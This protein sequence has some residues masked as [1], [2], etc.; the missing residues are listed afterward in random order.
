[1]KIVELE[2]HRL[3]DGGLA[4]VSKLGRSYTF[5]RTYPSFEQPPDVNMGLNKSLAYKMLEEALKNDV[6][7]VD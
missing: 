3:S 2:R 7:E 1:M 6:L 4:I 5:T